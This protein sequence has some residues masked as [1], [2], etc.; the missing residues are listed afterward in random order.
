MDLQVLC[1]DLWCIERIRVIALH[2]KCTDLYEVFYVTRSI[3]NRVLK[4]FS[5]ILCFHVKVS[6]ASWCIMNVCYLNVMVD[7]N[8]IDKL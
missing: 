5:P 8:D 6:C 1:I 7:L 2:V 3:N 4:C